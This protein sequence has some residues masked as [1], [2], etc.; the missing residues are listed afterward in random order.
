MEKQLVLNVKIQQGLLVLAALALASC[1][2]GSLPD[3]VSAAANAQPVAVLVA[4]P[5]MAVTQ[6]DDVTGGR[7]SG[8]QL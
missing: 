3:A 1:C 6:L 8:S 4:V 7:T 2:G 5:V